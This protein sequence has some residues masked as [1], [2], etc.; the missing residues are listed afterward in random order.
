MLSIADSK[1]YVPIKWC[2]TAGSIH[3]FKIAGTLTSDNVK[4][5]RSRIWDIMEIDWKE[6]NVTLNGNKIIEV[7][8]LWNRTVDSL[9]TSFHPLLWISSGL[10]E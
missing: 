10:K 1:Y 6:V 5:K 7:D 2:K 3:L 8:F 9:K 4:L